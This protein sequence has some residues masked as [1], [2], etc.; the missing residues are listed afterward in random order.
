MTIIASYGFGTWL[1]WLSR[2]NDNSYVMQHIYTDDESDISFRDTNNKTDGA[3]KRKYAL[4]Y[5]AKINQMRADKERAAQLDAFNYLNGT[6][7]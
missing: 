7:L 2:S 1:Q 5:A 6:K 4:A 3:M